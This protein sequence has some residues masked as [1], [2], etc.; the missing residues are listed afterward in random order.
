M[1]SFRTSFLFIPLLL[2]ILHC[3][4]NL[5]P[6]QIDFNKGKYTG[7][8]SVIF[9]SYKNSDPVTQ[10]GIISILFNDS[11]YSY[12]AV[13]DFSSDPTAADSLADAGYFSL[14]QDSIVMNDVSWLLMDP[15][16]HNSLYLFGTFKIEKIEN[17]FHIYQDNSFA[18]WD[19]LIAFKK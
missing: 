8:F 19:L 2:F 16:W 17:K 12:S 1:K 3:T 6:E 7:T 9:K 4:D 13:A 10:S 18:K 14:S 11:T 15:I 5:S